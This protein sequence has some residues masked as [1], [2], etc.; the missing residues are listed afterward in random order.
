MEAKSFYEEH[1]DL[2][3]PM[4]YVEENGSSL[5]TWLGKQKAEYLKPEHGM[6]TDVQVGLL[7]E[8]GI[9]KCRRMEDKYHEMIEAFRTY[10]KEHDDN[11]VPLNYVTPEGTTLGKWL[12]HQ[13]TEYR[14]GKLEEWKTKALEE[15]GM[16]WESYETVYARRYWDEM[17]ETAK[18]YAAEHGSIHDVPHNHVTE[19]GK[20]L[21]QWISQQ[22]GISKGT[23]KHSIEMTAERIALLDEIGMDWEPPICKHKPH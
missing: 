3:V 7:E 11:L 21:G 22:R 9:T 20:R 16:E 10:V 18:K 4:T 2:H 14:S 23:R 15:I 5:Y 8:I 17:Y 1:G 12:A 13:R 19:D 6:L